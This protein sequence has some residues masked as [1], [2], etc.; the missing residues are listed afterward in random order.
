MISVFPVTPLD[1]LPELLRE[2]GIGNIGICPANNRLRYLRYP[3]GDGST[4]YLFNNEGNEVYHGEIS[5][6]ERFPCVIYNAWDNCLE[7][8][9]VSVKDGKTRLTVKIEPFKLFIVIFD[10][11]LNDETQTGLIKEPLNCRGEA[12]QLNEGWSRSLCS[13]KEYPAFAE[14]REVS[15]PDSLAYEKPTFSGYA[16]YENAF[17]INHDTRI[18]SAPGTIL[19]I[20][21]AHE[22]VEVFINDISTGIQVVPPFRFDISKLVHPGKNTLVIEVATTLERQVGPQGFMMEQNREPASLSGITGRVNLYINQGN[23]SDHEKTTGENMKFS[24]K[25]NFPKV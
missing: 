19:E 15:L 17:Y 25:N 20:T 21:D 10:N 9:Q 6:P 3:H 11:A 2:N 23:N 7:K 12:L 16:R 8:L 14:N 18:N 24:I 22:G 5:V 1:K 13:G 4:V